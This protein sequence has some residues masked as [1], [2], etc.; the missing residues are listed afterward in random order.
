[1]WPSEPGPAEPGPAGPGPAK[2]EPCCGADLPCEP[3]S[4]DRT[5]I[6]LSELNETESRIALAAQTARFASSFLRWMEGRACDGL[7]YAR[8]QLLQ[9]LHCNG[10]TIMRDLAE[11]LG[12]SPRNMTAIVDAL[13]DADLV[14]RRRHPTDRR[15][16][17]IDLSSAGRQEAEQ[18]LGG[19]LD[20]MSQIFTGLTDDE[21]TQFSALLA[22]LSRAMHS[23]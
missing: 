6:D 13:E 17:V 4:G 3:E 5:A 19:R 14:V 2:A 1:M 22:K 20:S 18:D 16:T 12:A 7:S 9:A 11:R 8:L 23:D 15:A 10:P 21:R